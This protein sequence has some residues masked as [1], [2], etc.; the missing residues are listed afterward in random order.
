MEASRK[1]ALSVDQTF[2]TCDQ[3]KNIVYGVRLYNREPYV[4][5]DYPYQLVINI[6]SKGPAFIADTTQIQGGVRVGGAISYGSEAWF[7]TLSDDGKKITWKGTIGGR[8]VVWEKVMSVPKNQSIDQ[9]SPQSIL[10]LAKNN[11][12]FIKARLDTVYPTT[13]RP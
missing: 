1:V 12:K 2:W 10:N 13:F 5:F 8:P 9:Y 6:Y 7:G 4:N 11:T 3:D